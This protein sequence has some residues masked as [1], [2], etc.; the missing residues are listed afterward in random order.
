MMNR[1]GILSTSAEDRSVI[2]EPSVALPPRD[3]VVASPP[4]TEYPGR[5][6][7]ATT[8]LLRKAGTA[9]L[10]LIPGREI[11]GRA[12][13]TG[14]FHSGLSLLRRPHGQDLRHRHVL[15]LPA[16]ALQGARR[17][18]A[19]PRPDHRGPRV[20]PRDVL[21]D[22]QQPRP[23]DRQ[24]IRHDLRRRRAVR[25]GPDGPGHSQRR[26][27]RLGPAGVAE[28]PDRQD[29]HGQLG[30]QE[31]PTSRSWS[32]SWPITSWTPGS[33]SRTTAT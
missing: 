11:I 18:G 22:P 32:R 16:P 17:R 31:G 14:P 21:A 9:R 13:G 12:P 7:K 1:M 10:V 20:A 25:R 30:L 26:D 28:E 6:P 29:S 8:G 23:F 2:R 19:V 24:G 3:R 5:D 33:G 27:R 4:A 15:R